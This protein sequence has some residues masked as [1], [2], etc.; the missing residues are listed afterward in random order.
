M[1]VSLSHENLAEKK[2][3]RHK[4]KERPSILVILLP[5]RHCHS[6]TPK[7]ILSEIKRIREKYF[8]L[9]FFHLLHVKFSPVL[10]AITR[11]MH[12]KSCVGAQHKMNYT[13]SAFD[14]TFCTLNSAVSPCVVGLPYCLCGGDLATEGQRTRLK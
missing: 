13:F 10:R 11:H 6:I 2:A 1:Q 5:Q 7:T 3:F 4:S 12:H 14:S 9:L 8:S